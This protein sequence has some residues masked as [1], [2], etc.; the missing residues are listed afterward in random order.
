MRFI[1]ESNIHVSIRL[2]DVVTVVD[3]EKLTNEEIIA[4]FNAGFTVIKEKLGNLLQYTMMNDKIMSERSVTSNSETSHLVNC[5]FYWEKEYELPE[6]I[7]TFKSVELHLTNKIREDIK[8]MSEEQVRKEF[9]QELV[10]EEIIKLE[11]FVATA[12]ELEAKYLELAGGDQAKVKQVKKQYRE[13][14][15]AFH[16]NSLKVVELI[17][18]NAVTK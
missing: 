1:A 7:N 10:F 15:V 14:Q 4:L 18:A 2:D 6:E 5:S 3:P 9:L 11:G 17:K 13:A 8:K 16:I 12:E